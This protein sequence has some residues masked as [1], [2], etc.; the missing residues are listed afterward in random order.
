MASDQYSL[1]NVKEKVS[2]M[3]ENLPR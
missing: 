3:P 1:E 2:C